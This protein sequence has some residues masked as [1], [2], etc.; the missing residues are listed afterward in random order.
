MTRVTLCTYTYNDAPLAHELL[1][2]VRGWSRVPAATVVVDDGSRVPFALAGADPVGASTASGMHGGIAGRDVRLIRIEPNAGPAVAKSTGIS[3]ARDEFILSMDCDIRLAPGWLESAL[4]VAARPDVGIVGCGIVQDA[5]NGVVGRYL[6][7]F[8]TMR[9]EQGDTEFITGG[10]WLLRR[11]VW[12]ATNGFDGYTRRTH[13][14]HHFCRLVRARGLRLV[15][16][17]EAARQVRC[18]SRQV[19]IRR[20][21]AW[22]GDSVS[23]GVESL[24]TLEVRAMMEAENA[25]QRIDYALRH[26]EP[27]F[28]YLEML[29]FARLGMAGARALAQSHP[30]EGHAATAALLNGLYT[31]CAP[32]P[33]LS[34]LLREDCAALDMPIPEAACEKDAAA[35][36]D[37]VNAH[38]PAGGCSSSL[39]GNPWAGGLKTFATLEQAGL[40]RQLDAMTP[41]LREEEG[42]RTHFS[43]Y[44]EL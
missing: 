5:G 15:Q 19:L 17:G 9:V 24:E 8:D 38:S 36:M 43:F 2:S 39:P 34:A 27:L 16:H 37:A 30:A 7:H 42:E 18:F 32:Y 31:L 33:K 11:E 28:I 4:P 41:L 10:I 26:S 13:E 21:A 44:S 1:Q 20:F 25:I 35:G 22:L 6:R 3:A 23:A 29:L 40:F 12:Q 14:D